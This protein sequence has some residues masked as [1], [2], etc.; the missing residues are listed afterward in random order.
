MNLLLYI[1]DRFMD[2][3][4]ETVGNNY[5]SGMVKIPPTNIPA[6]AKPRERF[7]GLLNWTVRI[8]GAPII[9]PTVHTPL[10]YF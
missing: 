5:H 10:E 9:P 8:W 2:L 6:D 1:D 7:E 3:R 4:S